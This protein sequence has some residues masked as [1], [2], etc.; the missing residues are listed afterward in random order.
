MRRLL[1]WTFALLLLTIATPALAE[2]PAVLGG[3]YRYWVFNDGNDLRDVLAYWVPGPFHVQLE[4]W[5]HI[6]GQ[7]SFRPE[8]GIHLRDRRRSVYTVQWRHELNDERFWFMTDQVLSDHIVGRAEI[9]PIVT[10]DRSLQ[11]GKTLWVQGVGGDYYWGSYNF[12]SITVYHDPRGNDLFV[13]PMRVRF[14]NEQNDWLQLTLAPASQRSIG[15]AVDFKKKWVRA[16][17]ERNDRYDFTNTDNLIFTVG[18]ET[19]VP[20]FP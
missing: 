11:D 1:R 6:Q 17:I 19:T 16:G 8:I 12:A 4:Y 20:N 2:R 5:D 13:V 7:D 15:W 18:F 10:Y 14:A 3:Q 9:S